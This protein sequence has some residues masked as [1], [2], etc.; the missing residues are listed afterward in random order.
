M[1]K[2]IA[3]DIPNQ[4]GYFI[5]QY[6]KLRMLEFYYD[7]L[8]V[9]VSREN[10]QMV[11]MDTD[12]SYKMIAGDTLDEIIKPEYKDIYYK[13]VYGSCSDQVFKADNQFHWFPRK[14]CEYH[15][16]YD[17]RTP[18][19]FKLEYEGDKFIGLASK[20]YIVE[21]DGK[22]KFSCKGVSKKRVTNPYETFKKVLTTEK[23]EASTN[24]GF[25]AKNNSIFTYHQQR[26]AFS[27][28]YC[29]RVIESDGVSSK[30]LNVVLKPL[31]SKFLE[32]SDPI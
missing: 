27:Y 1:K 17:S 12:S 15:S 3:L 5:L 20:T 7:F 29:K 10:F 25:I 2:K 4:I 24:M 9:Y 8:D 6:A 16:K 11:E 14:C 31:K 23:A 18:G 26:A 21:N 19:L 22:V 32:E 28:F 30:P 13:S